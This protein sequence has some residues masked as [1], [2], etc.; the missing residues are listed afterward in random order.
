MRRIVTLATAGCLALG[1]LG[2]A[3]TGRRRQCH[4]A[5]RYLAGVATAP[6]AATSATGVP[7]AGSITWGPC[8]EPAPAAGRRRVRLRC[9][10]RWTTASRRAARSSSRSRGSGTPRPRRRTRASCWSTRAAPAAPASTWRC[11]APTCPS[12]PA[13]PTTGSASTPAASAPAS[14][15]CPA[16]RTTSAG[17]GRSTSRSNA[18]LRADVAGPVRRATPRRAARTAATLL[19]HLKTID[20]APR[21]W[22]TIRT[23]LGAEADQLLRLLLRHLPRPGLRDAVSRRGCAGWCSTATSTRARSGTRR[24]LDQDIA[25]ERIIGDLVRLA[26]EVRQRSTTSARP[27]TRSP[28]LLRA[29]ETTLQEHPAGGVG[30]PGRVGRRRSC[31]AGYYA[32]DL[33]GPRP[34][35][36][37]TG[38]TTTTPTQVI[39]AYEDTDTPGDDNGFAIYPRSQCTDTPW[40]TSW[41]TWAAD[42]WRAQ[43]ERAVRDLGQHLVQR[44]VPHLAGQGPGRR[45]PCDG[46]KSPARC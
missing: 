39:A 34:R 10:C 31:Y 16:T 27:R 18:A 42:N 15:R 6:A 17:R 1:T 8:R 32:V 46:G 7:S 22:T 20:S 33:A 35:R 44:A 29:S 9:R 40:P 12:T 3:G 30:R 4:G 21:T 25:F 2:A 38:C 13:T 14:R 43:P 11:S 37:P 23:A 26:R 28:A 36:S 5:R 19:D 41:S 45:S 24:N